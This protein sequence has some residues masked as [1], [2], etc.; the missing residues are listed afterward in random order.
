MSVLK[1]GF[2]DV[3][4]PTPKVAACRAKRLAS[5]RIS[6][7]RT[8]LNDEIDDETAG[9]TKNEVSKS[10]PREIIPSAIAASQT[11]V[12]SPKRT[13]SPS[14]HG[15]STF[16]NFREC[17]ISDHEICYGMASFEYPFCIGGG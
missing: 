3:S 9:N 16:H 10:V 14:A 7:M 12:L 11:S 17:S 15:L 13:H 6:F 5:S 8:V 2:E 1:R 4:S